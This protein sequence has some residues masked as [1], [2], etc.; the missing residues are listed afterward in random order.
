MCQFRKSN[1]RTNNLNLYLNNFK[2]LFCFFLNCSRLCYTILSA[3]ICIIMAFDNNTYCLL[4]NV[5]DE[6]RVV[7][8]LLVLNFLKVSLSFKIC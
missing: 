2:I 1:T 5:F 4:F 3:Y 7:E 6:H 8:C